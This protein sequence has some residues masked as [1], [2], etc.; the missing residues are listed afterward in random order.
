[1]TPPLPFADSR[2]L[3]GANLFFGQPG[4]VLETAGLEAD[5]ALL[6]GWRSRVDRARAH[7]GWPPA[8]AVSARRHAGGTSLALAAP[9]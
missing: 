9:A 7:L 4:A 2:R 3:T 1:M 6:D 8:L 5:A